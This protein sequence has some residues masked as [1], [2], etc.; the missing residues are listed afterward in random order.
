MTPPIS[1]PLKPGLTR[2][3]GVLSDHDILQAERSLYRVRHDLVAK[4]EEY[5]RLTASERESNGWMGRV[6]GSKA[7]QGESRLAEIE[8]FML[9]GRSSI[10]TGRTQRSGGYGAPGRPVHFCNEAEEGE[11]A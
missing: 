4:R 9:I 10:A 5:N 3:R 1:A 11:T 2:I 6:F 8:G 7:D